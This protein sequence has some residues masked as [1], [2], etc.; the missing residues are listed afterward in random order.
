VDFLSW[1]LAWA[2]RAKWL[3]NEQESEEEEKG[4]RILT[5][6]KGT[7]TNDSYEDIRQ[8]HLYSSKKTK[9]ASEKRVHGKERPTVAPALHPVTKL[10]LASILDL[11]LSWR[12]VLPQ[13]SL[14]A[15]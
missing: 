1:R 14:P 15:L 7:T 11:P 2:K 3:V 13:K 4:Y 5:N 8:V 9:E 12:Y 6:S 10:K